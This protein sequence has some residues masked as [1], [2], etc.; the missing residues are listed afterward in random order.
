LDVGWYYRL[1]AL[2]ILLIISAFFSGSEVALFSLDQKKLKDI[3]KN[4][5]ITSNYVLNLLEYPRR[6]LVT[7]L[8]G[9][10]FVNVAASIIAVTLALDIAELYNL[11][12]NFVL[13]A[14]IIILTILV[15]MFGEITPKVWAS[16]DPVK[17]SRVISFP[18]Y[19]VS[20]LIYP[21]AKIITEVIKFFAS[22]LDFGKEKTAIL[23]S[24]LTELAELSMEEGTIEEEEHE[25][26]SG[27]VSFKTVT[28]R[29][30]MTPRV[31]VIAVS[32][33]TD[34][35]ELMDI[36]VE[37]GHSRIPLYDE[38]LDQILGIIYAKDLL[39]YVGKSDQLKNNIVL[40]NLARETIF[41]PESKFISALMHEFQSKNL[42]LGIVVDEYGGTSGL[43]SLEDILEEIVGEIR[44]EYD[45][46]EEE[47]T[48]ISKDKY[49]LLG[50]TPIDE[51]NELMDYDFSSEDDDYDTIGGFILNHA[52]TIPEENYSF[53]HENFSF[54]VKE[55]VNNRIN[56]VIVERLPIKK[57]DK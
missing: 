3:Q 29:E 31:D 4:K 6:L 51:I 7:I 19:W 28:V 13:L 49:E 24:E 12:T 39:P 54:T 56:T 2:T 8:L 5:G 45:E 25:L 30:V 35:N 20:V 15:L 36:I 21:V 22:K 52:G 38:N 14:Q 34:F 48:Q 33:N 41:V 42:H 1:I 26:I 40:K 10:N 46:E 47:I 16:K 18:L 37:S 32:V 57:E 9:N 55:V 27:L 23:T 17:F 43:V 44:D 53:N 50:K 11:N